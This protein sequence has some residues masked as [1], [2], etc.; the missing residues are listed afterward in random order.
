MLN[1]FPL[2][3]SL[4]AACYCSFALICFKC[5]KTIHI[6]ARFK[7]VCMLSMCPYFINSAFVHTKYVEY[8]IPY[9]VVYTHTASKV[10][11]FQSEVSSISMFLIY[12]Y[13][14]C[15]RCLYTKCIC[16]WMAKRTSD[17]IP[18]GVK[19]SFVPSQR[20]IEYMV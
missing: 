17:Q 7:T 12:Q 5:L 19:H 18:E 4:M 8:W 14:V 9:T 10:L 16:I 3:T 15:K 13:A 6:L 20:Y 2:Q 11:A 1:T